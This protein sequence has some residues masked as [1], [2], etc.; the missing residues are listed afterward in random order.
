MTYL[1]APFFVFSKSRCLRKY[2]SRQ[3]RKFFTEFLGHL[4][5]YAKSWSD[6]WKTTPCFSHS[7]LG[8][9][10][11]EPQ[12][13]SFSFCVKRS[14]MMLESEKRDLR[15]KM[16]L[17]LSTYTREFEVDLLPLKHFCRDRF[18]GLSGVDDTIWNRRMNIVGNRDITS[19]HTKGV[20]EW[21]GQ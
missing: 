15:Q 21:L 5:P 10:F 19:S 2:A 18:T 14:V 13:N 20:L 7:A 4:S 3:S 1:C 17:V 12:V 6:V 8:G 9:I 16:R 11:A